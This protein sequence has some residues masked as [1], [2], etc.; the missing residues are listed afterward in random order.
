MNPSPQCQEAEENEVIVADEAEEAEASS[1]WNGG[2]VVQPNLN[3]PSAIRVPPPS[4]KELPQ[5]KNTVIEA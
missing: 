3:A 1:E 2:R 5:E 4:N